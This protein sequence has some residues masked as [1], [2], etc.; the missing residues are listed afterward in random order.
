MCQVLLKLKKLR[1][2]NSLRKLTF[3]SVIFLLLLNQCGNP[4]DI[5][6][7]K[8]DVLFINDLTK[9]V[10]K[11]RD[12]AMKSV[13]LQR[14]PNP[15]FWDPELKAYLDDYIAAANQAAALKINTSKLI[16]MKYVDSF[17]RIAPSQAVAICIRYKVR[18]MKGA[19]IKKDNFFRMEVLT[20]PYNEIK[21]LYK[22]EKKEESKTIEAEIEDDELD[23]RAELIL[24]RIM[25]HELT[26]CLLEKGHLPKEDAFKDHIMS[27][28]FNRY[29]D[30]TDKWDDMLK[31]NFTSDLNKMNS[32]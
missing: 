5:I 12:F 24:R 23:P 13:G 15:K 11:T 29:D 10:H 16:E 31:Q 14:K 7:L 30:L 1:E 4:K 2:K 32:L 26:H 17:S 28:E 19:K 27:P 8:G 18:Y 25:F 3:L 9:V 22:I 21:K 20:T 6:S